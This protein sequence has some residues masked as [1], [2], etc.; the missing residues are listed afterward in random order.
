M[1]SIPAGRTRHFALSAS[2]LNISNNWNNVPAIPAGRNTAFALSASVLNISNTWNNVPSIPAGR[3][4]AFAL[5]ASVLNISNAWN[6]APTIPAGRNTA[7][8][9]S[10]SVQNI[11]WDNSLAYVP[12]SG[13]SFAGSLPVAVCNRP[14]GCPGNPVQAITLTEAIIESSAV[15][16]RP[17]VPPSLEPVESLET[18]V[19]GRSLRLQWG[20]S[21]LCVVCEAPVDYEVNGVI[22]GRT[23]QAPHE[24]LFTVP[25]G[26]RELTFRA[27]SGGRA[28][29]LVRMIVMADEG[30][31]VETPQA[32]EGETV[33]LRQT[34]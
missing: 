21:S 9:L 34:G 18:V 15:K 20:R 23:E 7:T 25:S 27:I 17:V 32:S 22:V 6:S 4:T 30:S 28:S 31:A 12:P 10:A 1:P 3:N 14:S 2:V 26:V 5:S 16:D 19:E 11:F 33:S 8:S 13:R 29:R 24:F